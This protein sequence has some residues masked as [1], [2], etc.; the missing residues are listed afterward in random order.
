MTE[1]CVDLVVNDL[2]LTGTDPVSITRKIIVVVVD[3]T[4]VFVMLAKFR[5]ENKIPVKFFM[6]LAKADRLVIDIDVTVATHRDIM[7]CLLEDYVLSGCDS[8][9]ACYGIA[10]GTVLS[11]L[12]NGKLI[13]S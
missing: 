8:V 5:Y 3:D 10:K 13:E 9:C 6:I 4:E 12:R 2:I 1:C 11:S 7:T